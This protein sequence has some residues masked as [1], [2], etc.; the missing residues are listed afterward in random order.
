MPART[1]AVDGQYAEE[2]FKSVP[3]FPGERIVFEMRRK[4]L[5]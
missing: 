1:V 2:G 3:E 5:V 4:E